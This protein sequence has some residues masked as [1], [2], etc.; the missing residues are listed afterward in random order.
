VGQA[1]PRQGGEFIAGYPRKTPEALATGLAVYWVKNTQMIPFTAT[2]IFKSMG[3][4]FPRVAQDG[5]RSSF[6]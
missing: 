5:I 4:P 1:W 3:F 6:Q 2:N